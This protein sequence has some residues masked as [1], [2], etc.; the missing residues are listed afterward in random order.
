LCAR[1]RSTIPHFERFTSSIS[2]PAFGNLDVKR[3]AE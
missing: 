3:Q 2:K 1:S